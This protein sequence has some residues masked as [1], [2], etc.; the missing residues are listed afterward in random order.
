MV[1]QFFIPGWEDHGANLSPDD[2]LGFIQAVRLEART[3]EGPIT[4]HCRYVF[5]LS[6]LVFLE[7]IDILSDAQNK[8][9]QFNLTGFPEDQKNIGEKKDHRE[10]VRVIKTIPIIL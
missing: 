6:P 3:R 1:L 7:T 8:G 2:F 9:Q 4:V 5:L 10:A